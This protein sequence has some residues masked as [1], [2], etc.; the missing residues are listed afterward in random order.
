MMEGKMSTFAEIYNT[1]TLG[2]LT[3]FD[4]I[5]FKGYLSGLYPAVK[6]FD[7]FLYK[8]GVLL[9]EFKPYAEKTTAQL[10]AHITSMA[11]AAG[12]QVE[13]LPNG[14]GPHRESK[15]ELAYQRL[16]E[17][18][19]PEGLVAVFSALEL[20]NCFTV[21]GNRQT[22]HLQPV[23]EK[24]K[25]LHYYLY[26]NDL[27]LGLM[28]V[29]VQSWWPFEIHI[30]IN[31]QAW[32]ARQL[33]QTG[34]NYVR[35]ENCFV[36]IDDLVQAQKLADKFAHRQWE[37]VWNNFARRVNPFLDDIIAAVKHGYYWTIEQC[38]IATDVMFT[39]QQTLDD[40]LPTLFRESLLTFSAEDVMRFLG[41]KLSPHFAGKVE[42]RLNRRQPGWRV[43]HWLKQNSL[44]MYN[45][46]S[47]LRVETTVNNAGEFKIP[48]P[49]N[50]SS[51]W[52]SLPKGVSYFWH[53]YQIGQQANQRYLNALCQFPIEGKAAIDALDRLCQSQQDNGRSIAKFQP[54][55]HSCCHLFAAVLKGEHC[56][57]GFRNRH[58]RKLLFTKPAPDNLTEQRRRAQVSRLIAKLRGHHLIEKVAHSHLYRVTEHG[59]KVMAAALRYR[60]VEFP[61]NF[62]L[63]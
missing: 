49:D 9:K 3:M 40:I 13:Y 16:A 34:V 22:N 60:Q 45:K 8:Q 39:N 56:L 11:Q 54:V 62:A 32:L 12:C 61:N 6:Q 28:F 2:Q 10:K 30:H 14:L 38:E 24:R 5:I 57:T 47:V 1:Q 43:K 52:K 44:K 37:R 27:E 50:S 59:Y 4:R 25:H 42:T 33:D 51:R 58:L 55:S 23:I 18:D 36:Q 17:R 46:R 31:G 21:R 48:A 53:Y 63:A 20:H 29:R 35:Y 26:Y 7:W 41:R 19:E 15:E